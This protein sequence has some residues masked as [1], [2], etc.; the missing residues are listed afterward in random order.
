MSAALHYLPSEIM[1]GLIAVPFLA[2][3]LF[4]A[5][6]LGLLLW[7]IAREIRHKLRRMIFQLRRTRRPLQRQAIS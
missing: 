5:A 7:L 2:V 1:P 6:A 3:T 4:G